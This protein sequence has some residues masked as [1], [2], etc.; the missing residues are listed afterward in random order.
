MP[1]LSV[2]YM[3]LKLDNPLIVSSSSLTNRLDGVKRAADAG[4]GAVVLKSLFEEQIEAE[5]DR[6]ENLDSTSSHPEALDYFRQMGKHIGPADY[7]RLVEDSRKAVAIPVIASLNCVSGKW[8]GSYA[9]QLQAAGASGLELNIAIMPRSL[10]ESP[11]QLEAQFTR[12]VDQ[13]R[14]ATSLPIAV[15]I[16]PC[17]TNLPRV[18]QSLRA[19]GAAAVV[20]FNRFYQLDINLDRMQLAPGYQFSSPG[21]MYTTLR[22]ISI[23]AASAGCDLAASTGVHD[24][25]AAVKMLLAGASAVQ[26]CSALFI[27]GVKELSVIRDGI[28]QWMTAGKFK[29]IADFKGRLSQAASAD[30]AG[31]ERL[32]YIQALTGLQ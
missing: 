7:I 20:M 14:R 19:A 2:S 26:V 18:V 22:W 16:G 3:S 17:F 11:D 6:E 9:K 27:K 29:T 8:W 21:E 23:L 12:I 24:S 30:P 5:L 28:A 10:E 25:G 13:V 4:A 1:D 32:Q 15:K 31:Y